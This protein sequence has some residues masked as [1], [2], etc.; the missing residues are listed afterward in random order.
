[1]AKKKEETKEKL[2]I[3]IRS[4]KGDREIGE[5]QFQT[6]VLKLIESESE[7]ELREDLER[8]RNGWIISY[9]NYTF[10]KIEK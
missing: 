9:N 4:R 1:M 10:K 8:I 2:H 3:L 7:K 5:E 6:E